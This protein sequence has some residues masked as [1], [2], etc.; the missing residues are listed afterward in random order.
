MDTFAE[1]KIKLSF[2]AYVEKN[3]MPPLIVENLHGPSTSR[4]PKHRTIVCRHWLVGLCQKGSVCEYLHRLDKSRM[5][6]CKHNKLC[7]IRNC[8]LKHEDIEEKEECPY[9]KQGFCKNGPFCK[10]RHVKRSPDECP[11]IASF[12]PCVNIIGSGGGPMMQ[13]KRMQAQNDLY[14]VSICKHWLEVGS[15]PFGADW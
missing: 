9:Y 8:P 1:V 3:L 6:V 14:K 12:E 11:A 5:P 13:K 10:F 7:K 15:C 2:E 4:D